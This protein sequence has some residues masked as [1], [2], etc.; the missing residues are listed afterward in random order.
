MCTHLHSDHVGWNT[1]LEG[2]PLGPDLSE[3]PMTCSP[4]GSSR[5]WERGHPKFP[6]FPLED[7]VLPVIAAG[8]GPAGHQRPRPRRRGLARAHARPYAGSRRDLPRLAAA[9][10]R[11]CA[12]TS[13]T[14]R[15][16]ACI[17]S[18]RPGP[19]G[20]RIRPNAPAAP[21]WSATATPTRSICTAHF[22]LPSI[23][24]IVADG[25]AFRFEFDGREPA[26]DADARP[27]RRP[28]RPA[29]PAGGSPNGSSTAS[30][31]DCIRVMVAAMLDRRH[32]RNDRG[33]PWTCR[34][35]PQDHTARHPPSGLAPGAG[36]ERH[37]PA[38]A[39]PGHPG[40]DGLGRTRI[41]TSSSVGNGATASPRRR[42][43]WYGAHLQRTASSWT[44]STKA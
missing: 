35:D 1:R 30:I 41:C 25:D 18:G 8:Q 2:G 17:P 9:S 34:D 39:A 5:A 21:S 4:R 11:S 32:H 16:N 31:A 33:P 27:A 14:R 28:N 38:H 43:A 22:P 26:G 10:A 36:R 7:S 12:A 40:G 19:T 29:A 13:C 23:G 20:T 42:L 24:R 3:R 37:D 6:R 15:C 44:S